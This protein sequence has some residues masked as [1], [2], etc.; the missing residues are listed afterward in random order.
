MPDQKTS[1][2]YLFSLSVFFVSDCCFLFRDF[3]CLS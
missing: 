3:L 2:R 1:N